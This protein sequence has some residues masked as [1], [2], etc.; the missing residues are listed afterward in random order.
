ME[1]QVCL[2]VV[3]DDVTH[4]IVC[5]S[6]WAFLNKFQVVAACEAAS[7]PTG[8]AGATETGSKRDLTCPFISQWATLKDKMFNIQ[9]PISINGAEYPFFY[10]ARAMMWGVGPTVPLVFHHEDQCIELLFLLSKVKKLVDPKLGKRLNLY[11]IA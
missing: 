1:K 11:I 10:N 8:R 3:S 5:A 7:C 6:H 9:Q 2:D 4:L